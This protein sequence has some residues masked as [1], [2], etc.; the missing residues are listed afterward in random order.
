MIIQDKMSTLKPRE[1]A[2][3]LYEKNVELESKRRKAAQA[4]IPSDI[5]AWQQMRENY[6]AIILEDHGFSEQHNIEYALWQL[7][8]K[9]IEEFRVHFSAALASGSSATQNAKGPSKS[10]RIAKIRLQFKSFLS[11]ATGFYHDLI[12]KIKVK[13]GL[14]LGHFSDELKNQIIMERDS[15]KHADM[16]KGLVSWHRCLIYLGDIAR[17][18]GMYGDSESKIRDFAAASGCYLEASSLWPSSGNPHHQLAILASYSGDELVTVYRCFRSLAI[19]CPFPTAKENLIV[20]FEKNRQAYTQLSE[21]IS[22]PPDVNETYKSFRVQFV[23][24]NGVMFTRMSLETFSEVL[25]RVKSSLNHLLSSGPE[26]MLSFG[27]DAAENALIIVRLVAILI[28][29]A[30]NAKREIDGQ[31]Y[32][33]ILQ[34]K[35]L[36][37]NA[38]TAVFDFIGH[39]MSRCKEL[40]D[41]SSS[42]LLP[43]IL[44]FME[45]LASCPDIASGTEVDEKQAEVRFTF[46]NYF[47]AFLNKILLDGLVSTEDED[48][49]C[50]F[51]MGTYEEGENENQLALWEDFEL[52][53]FLP[54]A[55]AQ[56]ILDFSRQHSSGSKKEKVARVQRIFAA[57]KVL[58]KTVKV[59]QK[60]ICFNSTVK[61]FS[62]SVESPVLNDKSELL[63]QDELQDADMKR[64]VD[65]GMLLLNG[66]LYNEVERDEDEEDEVIV[67]K[68]IVSDKVNNAVVPSSAPH[69]SVV[70]DT[71]ASAGG[72]LSS[73]VY[74]P[75]SHPFNHNH[76]HVEFQTNMLPSAPMQ[77]SGSVP[78]YH[79]PMQSLNCTVEQL[80]DGFT[81]LGFIENGLGNDIRRQ[82]GVSMPYPYPSYMHPVTDSSTNGAIYGQL[83]PH[84]SFITSRVGTNLSS[85]LRTDASTTVSTAEG[86]RKSP[87]SR[88]NRHL[89]PPPGFSSVPRKQM[90]DSVFLQLSG[91]KLIDDHSLLEGRHMPISMS[92]TGPNGFYNHAS[93]PINYQSN[94]VK[95]NIFPFPG[96]QVSRIQS[97]AQQ[98]VQ[99]NQI[100]FEQLD[101]QKELQYQYQ[102]QL[103]QAGIQNQHQGISKWPG[104][105][106]V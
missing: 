85:G 37:D 12:L 71:Y 55:P 72:S 105:N 7:H 52:R 6:E 18:K 61:R 104:H 73:G 29:S 8:Y 89:G 39:I 66:Q 50:F 84:E 106:V 2:Q 80:A 68:P 70:H 79:G 13:Y 51:N 48:E 28:F 45:W 54:L 69:A 16:K 21:N 64:I 95:N 46:W 40:R 33:E 41:L 62:I 3:R 32:A 97:Q 20:A 1:V 42:C 91:K 17:Y 83:N 76:G 63:V 65:K 77:I 35:V 11:E 15:K 87:I 101:K 81:G 5:N 23:R 36:V 59:D 82:V 88:P 58:A 53:G 26:E 31:S 60:T 98:D 14:P 44:V 22:P 93:F 94:G 19:E 56:N 30:H 34:R 38:F 4:R 10:D 67:F 24:L 90:T 49:T 74:I 9:R 103:A 99:E 96:K 27:K 102:Q 100:S 78:Q 43:G 75:V 57:G 86:S 25:I 92:S 47:V